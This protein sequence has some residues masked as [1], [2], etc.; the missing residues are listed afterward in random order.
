MHY[1]VIRMEKTNSKRDTYVAKGYTQVS[2][3]D[4]HETFSPTARITSVCMLM[5]LAVQNDM[6]VYQMDV[7]KA[8]LNAL[9]DCEIYVK[10]PDGFDIDGKNGEKLVCKLK[11]SLY[12][13]KQSERN[14]NNMLH[15]YLIDK[16]F[17]H[18]LDP[19]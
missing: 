14:W 4:F 15:K 3:V 12:G 2:D 18:S 8:Y 9:I 7:K 19:S 6:V 16:H 10:Q 11:K 5:Q 1:N 17:E 13:L